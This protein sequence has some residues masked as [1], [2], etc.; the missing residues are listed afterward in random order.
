MFSGEI[1]LGVPSTVWFSSSAGTARLVDGFVVTGV[2]GG[3]SIASELLSAASSVEDFS[4][5][6]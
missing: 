2:F 5:L 6:F 3:V 1:V 4:D